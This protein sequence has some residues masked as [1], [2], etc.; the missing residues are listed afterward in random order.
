MEI[1]KTHPQPLPL[2][3]GVAGAETAA[4]KES[5]PSRGSEGNRGLTECQSA[6]S[7]RSIS[8]MQRTANLEG[9]SLFPA[10]EKMANLSSIN[11]VTEKSKGSVSFLVG[12]TEYA[13]P[14]GDLIDLDAERKKLETELEHLE[15]FLASVEKKLSNERF[16]QNAPATVVEMERKKQADA[17]QKIASIRETLANL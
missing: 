16:V 5:L 2:G 7:D 8:P 6:L 1:V 14:L 13:V 4:G 10:I 17:Q 11:V 12:T 15:G 3:R 9:S